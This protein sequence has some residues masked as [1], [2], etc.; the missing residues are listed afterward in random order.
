MAKSQA[1]A[2]VTDEQLDAKRQENARLRAALRSAEDERVRREQRAANAQTAQVLDAEN[3]R[4][5][6]L[7]AAAGVGEEQIE[8]QAAAPEPEPGNDSALA[9][10]AATEEEG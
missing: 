7:L 8:E 6:A 4:L 5:R 1:P 3:E 2:E 10:E 9:G